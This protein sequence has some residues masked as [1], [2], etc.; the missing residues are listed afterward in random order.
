MHHPCINVHIRIAVCYLAD[1]RHIPNVVYDFGVLG[2]AC[3]PGRLQGFSWGFSQRV[4]CF[5]GEL[6]VS[7]MLNREG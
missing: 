1:G 2:L 6:Q 3:T 7:H 4:C 5:A